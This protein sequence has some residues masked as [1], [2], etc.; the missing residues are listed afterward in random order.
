[1]ARLS[2]FVTGMV[3][4]RLWLSFGHQVRLNTWLATALEIIIVAAV[5]MEILWINLVLPVFQSHLSL[6]FWLLHNGPTPLFATL[7]FVAA[8]QQGYLTRALSNPILVW[9]GEISYS[10]YLLH[11]LLVQCLSAYLPELFTLNNWLAFFIYLSLVILLSHLNFSIVEDPCRK[12][13]KRGVKTFT[14]YRFTPGNI[15]SKN[16]HRTL[17][18]ALIAGTLIAISIAYV[19]RSQSRFRYTEFNVKNIGFGKQFIL[20]KISMANAADG[21]KIKLT[22][23]ALLRQHLNRTIVFQFLGA[24]KQWLSQFD[25]LDTAPHWIHPGQLWTDT[26]YVPFAAR[27]RQNWQYVGLRLC[28]HE[29]HHNNYLSVNNGCRDDWNTRLILPFSK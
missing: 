15:F 20:E 21:I 10:I 7:I 26:I 3:V 28:L 4:G 27:N 13:A 22:W 14:Q 16:Y 29:A 23:R 1:L 19:Q 8:L 18:A 2:E 12:L 25:K 17:L 9:L 6:S 24:Q 11:S 5:I